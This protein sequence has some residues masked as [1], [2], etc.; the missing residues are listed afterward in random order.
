MA[1]T[2]HFDASRFSRVRV[3]T[4]FLLGTESPRIMHDS[5]KAA[6]AALQSSRVEILPGQGH[7]AMTTAPQMFLDKV[8]GFLEDGR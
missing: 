1:E 6:A 8:L 4:L 7:A 2:Y 3:P 5:T